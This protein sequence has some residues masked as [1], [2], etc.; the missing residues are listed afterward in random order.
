MEYD[1]FI[2]DIEVGERKRA[3]NSRKVSALVQSI[4]AIG[5]QTPITVYDLPEDGK[6]ALIAGLHRLEAVKQLGHDAVAAFIMQAS[7][8]DREIWEIDENLIRAELTEIERSQHL[9]RRKEIFDAKN[10]SGEKIRETSPTGGRPKEFDKDTADKTGLDKSTVRKSR[11]RAETIAPDVQ[12]TI[13]TMAAGDSGVELDALSALKPDD[14]REAVAMIK[15][16][17]AES[18]REAATNIKV[19][20]KP[21]DDS[22][23]TRRDAFMGLIDRAEEGRLLSPSERHYL[24]FDF[25]GDKEFVEAVIKANLDAKDLTALAQMYGDFRSGF[26]YGRTADRSNVK[27]ALDLFKSEKKLSLKQA[28]AKTKKEIEAERE[29]EKLRGRRQ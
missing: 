18:V 26:A 23:K 25:A 28:I 22:A 6:F 21:K 8:A 12:K 2:A 20:V 24:I 4:E 3:I 15:S 16:G 11:R 27:K 5:L 19:S 29:E 14:Q 10:S 13:E 17:K 9:K 1:I 7:T